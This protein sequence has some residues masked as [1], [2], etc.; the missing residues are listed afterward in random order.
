MKKLIIKKW[1]T[2][3]DIQNN[4][5][6]IYLFGDNTHRVGLGGQAK[7]MRGEPN[8]IGIATKITPYHNDTAYMTDDHYEE[9]CKSILKDFWLVPDDKD[10]VLP[11]DGLGTGLANLPRSAPKTYQF[12]LDIIENL[13]ERNS[14]LSNLY[15]ENL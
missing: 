14:L 6:K 2:R 4:P 10:V 9:N 15:Q 11:A 3:K 7:E 13:K 1:I 5:D 8:S 12:I